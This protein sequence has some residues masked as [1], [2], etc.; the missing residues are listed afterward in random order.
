MKGP[1]LGAMRTHRELFLNFMM[2]ELRTRYRQSLLGWLWSMINPLML[3]LVYSL[4][5]TQFL[6]V[7]PDPGSP[8]GN[9]LFAFFL[10][11]GLLPW[12]FFTAS[13]NVG[14]GALIGAGGLIQKVKFPRELVVLG[15][16]AALAV[17]LFIELGVLMVALAF[18]GYF[19]FHLLPLIV[20]VTLLWVA[21]TMGIALVLAA[22]NIRYRDVMHLTNVGLLVL[23]Y[24]TPILYSPTLIPETITVAGIEIPIREILLN[25]PLNRFMQLYRNLLYDIRIPPLETLI[26]VSIGAI[27]V[28]W[29]GE[30]FFIHRSR[31]FPE[32][33]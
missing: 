33:L 29:A 30:R 27:L 31:R 21:F 13:L 23:F 18:F 16:I 25:S 28:F 8:S 14:M 5:F 3:T 1:T 11:S 6:V 4:V 12:N 7:T 9:D 24:L 19:T 2:R 26:G 20:L 17:S 10:L 22:L 15:P 32:E